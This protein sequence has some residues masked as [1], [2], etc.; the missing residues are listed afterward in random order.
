MDLIEF[1]TTKLLC[2]SSNV[3]DTT[4]LLNVNG[5]IYHKC[6]MC[7][8]AFPETTSLKKHVKYVHGGKTKKRNLSYHNS[9]K[10]YQCEQCEKSFKQSGDLKKHVKEVHDK[11]K[12]HHCSQCEKAFCRSYQLKKH[13]AEVHEKAKNYKCEHCGKCFSQSSSVKTHI[14]MVHE[15]VKYKCNE[16][17]KNFSDIGTL[18]LHFRTIHEGEKAHK[19]SF[20]DKL[21][22][23]AGNLRTHIANVHEG[24]KKYKCN[25]CDKVYKEDRNLKNHIIA[26][27]ELETKHKCEECGKGFIELDKLTKHIKF[28]H[29]GLKNMKKY[30]CK[31][32]E[33]SLSR[34]DKLRI[35]MINVHKQEI[36]INDIIEPN[37][38]EIKNQIIKT[39]MKKITNKKHKCHFCDKFFVNLRTL[40]LHSLNVHKEENTVFNK[41]DEN[42]KEGV[43]KTLPEVV[44]KIE[45]EIDLTEHK[46][47]LNVRFKCELCA[48][49]FTRAG[50]L[51]SHIKKVHMLID[52]KEEF[53]NDN[54]D[55]SEKNV[56]EDIESV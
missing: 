6:D 26:F 48:K 42:S 28:M 37:E 15:G 22:S 10:K 1:E 50:T 34:K 56:I 5:I 23:Q 16:C 14:N 21:F 32:C 7:S 51:K 44:M 13:F 40:K 52:I 18:K 20:C 30:N 55:D 49:A 25:Q 9:L 43:S 8:K 46:R 29:G 41:S 3:E 53:N 24:M 45:P 27:H 54:L 31:I 19:C 36:D 4:T 2:L 11:L 17:E 39:K 38:S 12:D 35:H 47:G 33:K